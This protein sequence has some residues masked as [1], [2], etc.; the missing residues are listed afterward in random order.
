MS[1]DRDPFTILSRLPDPEPDPVVMNATIAQS[2]EAFAN[3]RLRAAR[4]TPL[5]WGNWLRRSALWL[6]PAGA[7]AAALAVAIVIAPGLMQT[8]SVPERNLVADRPMPSP[9]P[10]LSRSADRPGAPSAPDAGIRMGVQPMPGQAPAEPQQTFGLIFEGNDIRIGM[11]LSNHALELYLPDTAGQ[12]VLDTQGIVPGEEVELLAAF[13]RP[14][15]NLIAV[16]FR[17]DN[18]RFWR[19]YRPVDGV[20]ARD[21][22]LSRLVS[23]AE[24]QAEVERR[25]AAN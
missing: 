6:V 5:S 21:V 22:E 7:G 12:P 17:V 19:I 18:T 20:Y 3:N 1:Q 11:Y 25:L 15:E 13:Q 8:Q 4:D 10:E 24:D 9:S 2:R 16:R 14:D 23:D